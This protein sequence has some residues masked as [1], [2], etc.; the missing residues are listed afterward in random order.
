MRAVLEHGTGEAC[1]GGHA[2]AGKFVR[3][4]AV[5]VQGQQSGTGPA[6]AGIQLHTQES[7][8][9]QAET[10][11]AWGV[12]G[13][14]I[15]QETLG[16]FFLLRLCVGSGLGGHARL[17]LEVIVEVDVAQLQVGFAVFDEAGGPCGRCQ[18][19]D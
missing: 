16:P 1:L 3:G 5:I 12:A 2:Q 18:A 11:T 14:H 10:E 8:G 13:L 9:V 19:G 6:G 17:V 4:P 15:Q 7:Q